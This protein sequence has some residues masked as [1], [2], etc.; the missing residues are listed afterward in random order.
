MSGTTT[1]VHSDPDILGGAPVF[2]GTQV[3]AFIPER[4]NG[5]QGYRF[6]DEGT[7][8]KLLSGAVPDVELR[9]AVA[10]L[11]PA[12][13]NQIARWLKQIDDLRQAA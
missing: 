9:D 8:I 2:Q 6:H 3:L 10:S 7:I 4:R 11:T 5:Q 13:W 1:V 12:S